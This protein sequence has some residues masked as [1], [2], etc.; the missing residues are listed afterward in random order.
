MVKQIN[1]QVIGINPAGEEEVLM[2]ITSV[3][4]HE[5]QTAD[6]GVY[7]RVTVFTSAHQDT[8]IFDSEDFKLKYNFLQTGDENLRL[9]EK[10]MM[11]LQQNTTLSGF[12]QEISSQ[13]FGA[14]MSYTN[15]SVKGA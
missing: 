3:E 12:I 15:L 1:K 7:V 13:Y 8:F 11:L 10:Y 6:Y 9:L 4:E 5:Q 2:S 14:D